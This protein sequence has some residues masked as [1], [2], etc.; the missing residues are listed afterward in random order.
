MPSRQYQYQQRK[1]TEGNCILCGQP[2]IL[3]SDG[4]TS[5]HCEDCRPKVLRLG[6]L[7]RQKQLNARGRFRYACTKCGRARWLDAPYQSR[8]LRRFMRRKAGLCRSCAAD[9]DAHMAPAPYR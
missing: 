7:F 5:Q 9:G 2:A 3:N 1:R 6:R 4:Q 8:W